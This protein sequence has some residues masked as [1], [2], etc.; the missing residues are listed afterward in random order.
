MSTFD[1]SEQDNKSPLLTV[2]E[3]VGVLNQTLEIAYPLV[4]VI[5]ELSNF[6][7]SKNRWVYF[8]LIDSSA[9]V[10]CFG[11]IYMLP[12]PLEDGLL[13]KITGVPRLHPRFNFSINL[14]TIQPVGEGSLKR[15][16]TLLEAKLAAE[17]LFASERKRQLPRPPRRIGLITSAQSA[18]YADFIKILGQRWGGIEVILAD[19]Q[20][21]GEAAPAQLLRAIEYFN[22]AAKT[23]DILVITRG[24][25]SVEDL[26]AFNTE[27]V[28]R[29]VATSRIPTLVA[30]GHEV[31]LS[32][33]ELVADKRASTPSNAAEL[34]TPDKKFEL[35]QLNLILAQM[36]S[37]AEHI[38]Q[39]EYQMIQTNNT[40]L[41]NLLQ[42]IIAQTKDQL[43]ARQQLLWALNPETILR[44]GYAIVRLAGRV[45]HSGKQ[46]KPGQVVTMQLHDAHASAQIDHIQI[47]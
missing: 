45:V 34:L 29:A 41:T 18:A 12:G 40:K 2:S 47:Q 17:G 10:K 35:Q 13:V 5:G 44:R 38:L 7:I 42:N 43:A 26:A 22:R 37:L 3:F 23:P 20:V 14:Q 19:V 30:I 9:A 36:S 11:T 46:L 1:S 39:V 15:I 33:A 24:G 8:D 32:L 31:D 21:Q 25:G 6:R 27:M 16:T 28:T 4:S